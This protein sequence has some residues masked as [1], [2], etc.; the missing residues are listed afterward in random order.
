MVAVA[1]LDAP[2]DTLREGEDVELSVSRL[3]AA[4]LADRDPKGEAEPL[5]DLLVDAET[6]NERDCDMVGV[7]VCDVVPL[8]VDDVVAVAE[9]DAPTDTL[10]EEVELPVSRL[11]AVM[12]TDC[13]PGGEA[14]PLK[15]LLVDAE[16]VDEGERRGEMVPEGE[17]EMRLDELG[18]GSGEEVTDAEGEFAS[19]VATRRELEAV[20]AA[21]FVKR[22]TL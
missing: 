22:V 11:D 5:K 6:V 12:L 15:D 21:D 17:C 13:E 8:P 10:R 1:E 16:T 18:V 9:P 4:M 19:D 2:S 14:E 3:E 20:A 7:H